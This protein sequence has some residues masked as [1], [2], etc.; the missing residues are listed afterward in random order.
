MDAPRYQRIVVDR[1]NTSVICCA[2]GKWVKLLEA[3]ADREG[4]S[5]K[6]YFHEACLPAGLVKTWDG[7][8]EV[9]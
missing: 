4:A 3:L 8:A 9:K 6:S 7:F 1:F 2:C 5:F